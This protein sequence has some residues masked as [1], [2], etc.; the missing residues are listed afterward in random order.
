MVQESMVDFSARLA[1]AGWPVF[2]A[3]FKPMRKQ[4]RGEKNITITISPISMI[5]MVFK[6]RYTEVVHLECEDG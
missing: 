6:R 1:L 2:R 4:R 5:G 3:K